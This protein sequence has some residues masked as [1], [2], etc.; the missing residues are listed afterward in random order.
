MLIKDN[1]HVIAYVRG[2]LCSV[3]QV[4]WRDRQIIRTLVYI[5]VVHAAFFLQFYFN[6]ADRSIHRFA[7]RTDANKLII[8]AAPAQY[9]ST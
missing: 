5:H 7:D 1:T 4:T 6:V 8:R 9:N 3:L 2:M